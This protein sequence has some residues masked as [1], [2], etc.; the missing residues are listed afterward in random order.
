[1]HGWQTLAGG[2]TSYTLFTWALDNTSAGN[3]TV[4]AP[5]SATTGASATIGLT[6]SGLAAATRYLGAV[7]YSNGS[8]IG[9]TIVYQKTP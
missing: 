4:S 5:S 8:P 7:D 2:T 1:M 6:F 9:S 3:M